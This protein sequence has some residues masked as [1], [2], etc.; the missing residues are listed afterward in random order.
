MESVVV[1]LAASVQ[2]QQFR[3]TG[4]DASDDDTYVGGGVLFTRRVPAREGS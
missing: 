3:T 4:G 2:A 1:N